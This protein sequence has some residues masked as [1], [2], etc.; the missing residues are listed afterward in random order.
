MSVNT[1]S[2]TDNGLYPCGGS[3][4]S[5]DPCSPRSQAHRCQDVS[6]MQTNRRRRLREISLLKLSSKKLGHCVKANKIVLM[7]NVLAFRSSLSVGWICS[8]QLCHTSL[9]FFCTVGAKKE[10]CVW[11]WTNAKTFPTCYA[12]LKIFFFSS[13]RNESTVFSNRHI[14]VFPKMSLLTRS[15]LQRLKN[16]QYSAENRSILD[17]YLQ[18]W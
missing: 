17:P 16:H 15:Q 13:N 2:S 5:R 8:S 12:L 1:T 10:E 4:K 11:L 18:P 7:K 9:F 14:R 3:L 6:D